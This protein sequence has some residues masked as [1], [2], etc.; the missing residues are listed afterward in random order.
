MEE[1]DAPQNLTATL[2]MLVER[3][4]SHPD[5]FVNPKWD[6]I[7]TGAW[8]DEPFNDVR[9][10]NFIQAFYQSGKEH[11]FEKEEIDLFTREYKNLIRNQLDMC[12]VKELVSGERAKEIE[13]REKQMDLPYASQST[14]TITRTTDTIKR[15]YEIYKNKG[16]LG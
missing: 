9:W 12:I 10:T 1:Q 7:N 2:R 16:M 14:A 5:E 11:L 8:S 4:K 3:M 13:F 6:P 15:A